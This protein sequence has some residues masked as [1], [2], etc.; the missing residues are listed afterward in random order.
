MMWN[1][2]TARQQFSELIRLTVQEPQAIY[3]HDKPVAVVVSA[4]EFEAFS[5]WREGRNRSTL[6][7]QFAELRAAL[8]AEGAEDG[9]EIPPRTDRPNPVAD[10]DPHDRDEPPCDENSALPLDTGN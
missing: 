7:E 6:L 5:L 4:D 10:D 1:M 3:S 2:A 8:I 9:I